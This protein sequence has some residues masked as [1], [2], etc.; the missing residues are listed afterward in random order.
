MMDVASIAAAIDQTLLKPTVGLIEAT[1]WVEASKDA[2]F[3]TL[4]V[5]P[6]LVP[7]TVETLA[8]TAT[9]T[10]SVA[11]FPL[12]YA[13]TESK[14]EEARRLAELGCADVDMVINVAALLEG[15]DDYVRAD[16]AAV[17]A[18]VAST[19]N[20]AI[21]KVILETAYL[22]ES[23]IERACRLCMGAGA[24][25]VK[26]STGFGPR[27]ASARDCEIMRAVVGD[28]LGVK[29]AGGIRDLDALLE[30]VEAGADRIGTSAGLE[31]VSEAEARGL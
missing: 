16:I 19:N 18:A 20:A 28:K 8:G 29:A 22:A 10:C 15:S 5:S 27:G 12:G 3:A 11:G 25:Y 4:C 26:T 2:G 31:I 9:G 30:M 23:D 1:E 24:H 17:V 21:V 6:F 14:A 13:V 7:M